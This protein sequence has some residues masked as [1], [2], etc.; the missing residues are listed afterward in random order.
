MAGMDAARAAADAAS[1]AGARRVLAPNPGPMTLDGTNTWVL[2][3]PGSAS[4]IVVDPGPADAAHLAALA[5]LPVALIVVTHHHADHTEAA[6]ELAERTGAAV[7]GMDAAQC[8]HAAPLQDGEAIV[9]AGLDIQVIAAPGHT[10]DSLCLW[11]PTVGE[12]GAMIT[13]DTILG[14]GTT[15]IMHPDGAVGDYFTTLDRLEGF[16]EAAVL[17]GHGDPLPALGP[18]V[19]AYREHRLLRLDEIRS[20]L[21]RLGHAAAEVD[22][23]TVVDVVYRDIDPAVRFAAEASVRAQLAYLAGPGG[24]LAGADTTA[25]A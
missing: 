14:R 25:R 11:M 23:A 24:G 1:A 13:G 20:A 2:Q 3:A 7:R 16:G 21:A 4:A 15:V 18:I 19:R 22:A 5:A 9:G 6:A 8:I 10:S 12:R 17:P